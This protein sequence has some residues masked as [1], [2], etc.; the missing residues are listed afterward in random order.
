MTA[1]S[2]ACSL[3]LGQEKGGAKS[4]EKTAI[5]DWLRA[6]DLRQTLVSRDAAGCQRTNADLIVAGGGHCLLAL[7]KNMPIAY[8]QVDEHFA[9]RLDDL[10]AAQDLNFGSGRIEKR[11]A[12]VETNL[13]LLDGL[14]DWSRL[15]AFK[16]GIF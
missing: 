4:T 6:L 15:N 9:K 16:L 1:W 10:P 13:A 3:V 8:E 2:S 14:R 5:P 12:C 11:R 7:K